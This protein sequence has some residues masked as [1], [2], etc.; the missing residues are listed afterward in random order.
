MSAPGPVPSWAARAARRGAVWLGPL[1]LLAACAGPPDNL[2][3][4]LGNDDGSVGRIEVITADGSRTLAESRQATGFD[5]SGE[6]PLAPF[7][8]ALQDLQ[9]AFRDALAVQPRAAQVHL[10][11]F[12]PDSTELM[13]D[14]ADRLPAIVR[15][16][17]TR[18]AVDVSVVGHADRSG[19][20]DYNMQLSL[21]RAEAVRDALAAA[22]L[23][24]GRLEVTSH[25]E[26]NPLVP[27]DD[28][29]VE[30]RNRRVEITIR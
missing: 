13:P 19:A 26:N 24:L 8:I 12:L 18:E 7:E 28:G 1:W 30:P 25:G 10:L 29:V 4:L 17:R 11:Y 22:G 21:R 9:D 16:I 14:S 20:A 27:T 6:E 2:F 3:V 15:A 5:E 23:D